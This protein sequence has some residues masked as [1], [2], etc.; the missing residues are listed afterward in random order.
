MSSHYNARP[1]VAEVMVDGDRWAIVTAREE[2]EDLVRQ[3][4]ASPV[5]SSW[6][7]A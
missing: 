6:R 5:Y 1:R 2:Y 3:E 7:N 4:S